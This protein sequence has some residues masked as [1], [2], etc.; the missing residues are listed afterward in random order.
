M[1]Y[2]NHNPLIFAHCREHRS[3]HDEKVLILTALPARCPTLCLFSFFLFWEFSS[4]VL[5]KV[6][7][8]YQ[9]AEN[10]IGEGNL[11]I[12]INTFVSLN[13]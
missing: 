12:F 4:S 9:A 5:L 1:V 11:S 13:D 3:A 10:R 7:F 2:A 8:R 6:L